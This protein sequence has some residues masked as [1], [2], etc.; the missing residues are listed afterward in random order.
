MRKQTLEKHILSICYIQKICSQCTLGCFF[1][2]SSSQLA[3]RTEILFANSGNKGEELQ[4]YGTL[5]NHRMIRKVPRSRHSTLASIPDS[6][7]ED[8]GRGRHFSTTPCEQSLPT[9]SALCCL[10]VQPLG[11]RTSRYS[12]YSSR[13]CSTMCL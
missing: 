12:V 11:Y 8:K 1:P 3:G 10:P 7:G 4:L 13:L 2:L 5:T 6:R 9:P